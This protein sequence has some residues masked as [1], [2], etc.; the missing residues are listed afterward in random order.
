M[1]TGKTKDASW[2]IG[3]STT[4]DH[5]IDE[6]GRLLVSPEGTA[7]WLDDGVTLRG[8][9]GERTRLI[10]HQERLADADERER[11]STHWKGVAADLRAA[12]DS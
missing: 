10:L 4:L 2:Q 5:P 3:V 8:D 1:P 6:V 7:L 12:L 9:Q 11:Q